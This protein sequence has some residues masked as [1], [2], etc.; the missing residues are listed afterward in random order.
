[1]QQRFVPP[2]PAKTVGDSPTD[3]PTLLGPTGAVASAVPK[4]ALA[5]D[6][7]AQVRRFEGVR[8]QGVAPTVSDP[9]S[10]AIRHAPS[11]TRRSSPSDSAS[12]WR[13][14]RQRPSPA[15]ESP[16]PSLPE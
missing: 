11:L 16:S 1:M 2:L 14:S 9:P 10:V 3:P 8:P 15:G 13:H 6:V 12:S 7:P 5:Q 4:P